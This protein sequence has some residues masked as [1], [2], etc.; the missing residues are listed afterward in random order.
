M[1]LSA[2]AIQDPEYVVDDY[3]LAS[4]FDDGYDASLDEWYYEDESWATWEFETTVFLDQSEFD[5]SLIEFGDLNADA[6]DEWIWD[7][8]YFDAAY[9]DE[10]DESFPFGND[11]LIPDEDWTAYWD[12]SFE[13]DVDDTWILDSTFDVDLA[14]SETFP[15]GDDA[16]LPDADQFNFN[17]DSYRDAIDLL[18]SEWIVYEIAFYE[19]DDLSLDSKYFETTVWDDAWYDDSYDW[20][21]TNSEYD[22][23]FFEVT[24]DDAAFYDTEF[25]EVWIEED[26][27][28][29]ENAYFDDEAGYYEVVYVDSWFWDYEYDDNVTVVED[30][31]FTTEYYVDDYWDW[32][33]EY[34]DDSVTTVSVDPLVDDFIADASFDYDGFEFGDVFIPEFIDT[35]FDTD[36]FDA[37]FTSD[38]SFDYNGFEFGDVFV[39]ELFDTDITNVPVSSMDVDS[40][41]TAS[42]GEFGIDVFDDGDFFEVDSTFDTTEVVII[43]IDVFEDGSFDA[44]DA[45]FDE[46]FFDSEFTT[47]DSG[48][49][50]FEDFASADPL[51]ADTTDSSFDDSGSFGID[52]LTTKQ[53][54]TAETTFTED[55]PLTQLFNV[56]NA[57]VSPDGKPAS[58]G[59]ELTSLVITS[60]GFDAGHSTGKATGTLD[61]TTKAQSDGQSRGL[62]KAGSEDRADRVVRGTDLSQ[63]PGRLSRHAGDGSVRESS[64]RGLRNHKRGHRDGFKHASVTRANSTA[65]RSDDFETSRPQFIDSHPQQARQSLPNVP[66]SNVGVVQARRAARQFDFRLARAASNV[67]RLTSGASLGQQ[68]LQVTYDQAMLALQGSSLSS[69]LA[70]LPELDDV[71]KSEDA[72][73]SATYA[74]VAS[75]AGAVA[76]TSAAGFQ[77][78]QKHGWTLLF[79]ALRRML[80]RV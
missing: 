54:F 62:R 14:D 80:S 77:F 74:Q 20:D 19:S 8:A 65:R 71:F 73:G 26:Y 2:G 60:S 47:N 75:A 40:G 15:F 70:E 33:W 56:G 68:H 24:Y 29:Y 63:N 35:G 32:D 25:D 13:S 21:V 64:S 28:C 30:I 78:S 10:T 58:S 27:A 66:S 67:A 6:A 38:S 5:E 34:V 50:L 42:A 79:K 69:R 55:L 45:S 43:T 16:L 23:V 52:N 37:D 48:T 12:A 7:T 31:E 51:F 49:D 11:A 3:Q 59:T 72:D 9:F 57:D 4:E 1:Y 22:E 18:D 76:I 46:T 36:T 44:S 61:S 39:S 41:I 17:S 53:D